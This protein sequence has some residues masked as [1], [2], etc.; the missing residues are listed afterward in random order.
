GQVHARKQC[1]GQQAD[2]AESEQG[3]EHARGV[4]GSVAIIVRRGAGAGWGSKSVNGKWEIVNA[5]P[6][7]ES[8]A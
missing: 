8:Q 3:L 7:P 5:N 1:R 6:N 2:Q 4:S